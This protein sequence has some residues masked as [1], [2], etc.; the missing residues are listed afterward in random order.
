VQVTFT[1]Y[2]TNINVLATSL[3]LNN[4]NHIVLVIFIITL[5]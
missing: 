1:P 4:K 5:Y 3:N 2:V